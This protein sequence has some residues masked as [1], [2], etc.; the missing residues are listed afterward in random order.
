[1]M[2]LLPLCMFMVAA[3]AAHGRI[4][5]LCLDSVSAPAPCEGVAYAARRCRV[6]A[7]AT[8]RP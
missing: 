1:M 5:H 4:T 2:R 8:Q 3:F 6:Y 7:D